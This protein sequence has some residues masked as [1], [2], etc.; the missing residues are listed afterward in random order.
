MTEGMFRKV[1]LKEISLGLANGFLVG[2]TASAAMFLYASWANNP[3]AL[4]LALIVM[5][6]MIGSCVI[7]GLTGVLVP[8]GLQK[9]GADP[10]TASAIFLTTATDVVSMGMFLGFATVLVL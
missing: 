9:V 10:T 3:A 8:L 5:L 4:S 2:I 6:A 7:S 1:A